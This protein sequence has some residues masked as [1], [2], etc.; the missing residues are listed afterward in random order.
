NSPRLRRFAVPA[1]GRRSSY[2]CAGSAAAMLA[3]PPDERRTT[4]RELDPSLTRAVAAGLD[5][6]TPPPAPGISQA[7]WEA[8]LRQLEWQQNEPYRRADCRAPADRMR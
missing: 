5:D 6:V 2:P 7:D 8:L 1:A 3:S 4:M